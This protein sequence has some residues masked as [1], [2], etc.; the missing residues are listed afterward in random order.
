MAK[1]AKKPASYVL[2]GV[3]AVGRCARWHCPLPVTA[4]CNRR[5]T[6]AARGVLEP[7]AG[8]SP[9]CGA[10]GSRLHDLAMQLRVQVED[11]QAEGPVRPQGT[12]GGDGEACAACMPWAWVGPALND[13]HGHRWAQKKNGGKFPVHAKK[14]AAPAPAGKAP[15]FYP[16]DDVSKPLSH[17]AV[18]KPTKLRASITPGTVLI[19]LSGRFKGKRVIFLAQLPS[20]LLLVTGPFK[21]N[22]VPVR[23]VHQAY[24]IATSTKV[25]RV[26]V[27]KR[28][29]WGAWGACIVPAHREAQR[30]M[31]AEPGCQHVRGA[32]R[33]VSHRR[34]EAL[35]GGGHAGGQLADGGVRGGAV[36]GGG[37]RAASPAALQ[38]RPG[39]QELERRERRGTWGMASTHRAAA[40]AAAARAAVCLAAGRAGCQAQHAA[41]VVGTGLARR[42]AQLLGKGEE[43]GGE[44]TS[45]GHR[46]VRRDGGAS[47]AP[48]QPRHLRAL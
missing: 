35:R 26:G 27:G 10:G 37:R 42:T 22:G 18:H 47:H 4:P 32:F 48:R 5:C 25:G 2:P 40:A 46:G 19:L 28:A 23:R 38:G 3:T 44:G 30:C 21:V 1:M 39:E 13:V 29:A 6:A 41:A 14:V 16:A 34:E 31:V 15:R 12:S 17:N 24:A 20:G 45:R 36:H 7:V 11:L 43:R 8:G 9:L 33:S